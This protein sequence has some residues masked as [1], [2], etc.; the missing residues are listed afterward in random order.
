VPARHVALTASASATDSVPQNDRAVAEPVL[1]NRFQLPPHAIREE[2]FQ[3]RRAQAD[4][5]L[6]LV[7]KTS[8]E[9]VRGE[10]GPINGNVVAG[11]ALDLPPL[12]RIELALDPRS[13]A[14]RLREG[15]GVNDLVGRLP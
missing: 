3:R 6:K 15:S 11:V 9:R 10:P 8:P 2:R 5:H 4:D 14:A 12:R 7:N 1:V 13:H